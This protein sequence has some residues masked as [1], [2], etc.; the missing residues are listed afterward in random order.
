MGE[1]LLAVHAN[2]GNWPQALKQVNVNA[3]YYVYREKDPVEFLPWDF[4]DHGVSREFL[5]EEYRKAMETAKEWKLG[6][7]EK[8]KNE[9]L[10]NADFSRLTARRLGRYSHPRPYPKGPPHGQSPSVLCLLV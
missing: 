3:D 8:N 6:S 9:L 2:G 4:I 7:S 1:I 10:R 5:L